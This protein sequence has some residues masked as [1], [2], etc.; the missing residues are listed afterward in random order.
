MLL[1]ML[2][3]HVIKIRYLESPSSFLKPDRFCA[4]FLTSK[5]A[6]MKTYIICLPY[7]AGFHYG[8]VTTLCRHLNSKY[9][10]N[11]SSNMVADVDTAGIKT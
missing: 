8:R 7:L 3:N 1:T 5:Q 10:I 11:T 9:A 6:P 4:S 2:I